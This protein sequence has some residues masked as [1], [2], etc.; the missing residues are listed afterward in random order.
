MHTNRTLLTD[1]AEIGDA[2]RYARMARDALRRA[3]ASKAA[4]ADALGLR[5]EILTP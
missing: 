4:A 5:W 2:H 3:G 1:A